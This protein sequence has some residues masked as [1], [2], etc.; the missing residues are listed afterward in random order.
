MI[1]QVEADLRARLH[2]LR[3]ALR[4]DVAVLADG[5]LVEEA[6][7]VGPAIVEPAREH[8]VLIDLLDQNR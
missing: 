6:L 1:V 5:E 8:F 7:V 4:Q 2:Q 3:R